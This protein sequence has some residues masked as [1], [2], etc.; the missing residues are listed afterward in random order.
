MDLQIP[1]YTIIREINHGGMAT[2]YLAIQLSVGREVALKIMKPELDQDPEF[3]QRFKREAEI[4]GQLPHPN[5]VSINDIGRYNGLNYISMDYLP[6]GSLEQKIAQGMDS[7]TA[8]QVATS[9]ASALA[10]AHGKGYVHRDIKPENILFRADNSAVLTDFGIARII[11]TRVQMTQVGSVM[12]TPHYMSPEQTK[13]KELDG[14][15]DLYS[16]GIVLYEMLTGN[17]PFHGN[18]ALVIAI[19]HL[20]EPVPRLPHNLFPYQ[21]II[22]K[23]LAKNPEERFQTAEELLSALQNLSLQTRKAMPIKPRPVK[24]RA[25]LYS[26]AALLMLVAVSLYFFSAPPS[27]FA[28]LTV[29]TQ[30]ETARVRI[31]NIEERYASGIQLSPGAYKIEVTAPGYAKSV[32][33]VDVKSGKQRLNYSLVKQSNQENLSSPKNSNLTPEMVSIAAGSFLMGN[34]ADENSVAEN[35]SLSSRYAMSKFE[36]TFAQYDHFAT[37]TNRS[38]PN[39]NG[40]GRDERPVINVSW[41]DAQAYVNWLSKTT[42]NTY[43]L[44]N[45]AEWEYAARGNTTS[46]YWWGNEAKDAPTRANCRFG[47]KSFLSALFSYKTVAVGTYPAND[48]GLHDTAGNVAEWVDGC[49]AIAPATNDNS[50]QSS[51]CTQRMVR[52]GSMADNV[53]NIASYSRRIQEHN[54]QDNS[55]GFRILQVSTTDV[56]EP[57]K[58]RRKNLF[59]R[60]FSSD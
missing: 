6:N 50:A 28:E 40:W 33:W 26:T 24:T 49:V 3:H 2:V 41:D 7:K 20:H 5:I 29:T 32:N 51:A 9:M 55:I 59:E 11:H 14:R 27:P 38:L 12:G 54:L 36:I 15:S 57:V 25:K 19:Q 18:D 48:F 1:G 44:P 17:K 58:N 35:V 39:D 42:G 10:L 16:L 47:C 13:A 8:L 23:L 30:P 43:R 53:K 31:L 45:E 60:I 21:I 34:P 4:V 52:G 46:S 37:A 56:N 22:D